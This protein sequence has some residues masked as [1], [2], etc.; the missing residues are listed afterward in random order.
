MSS[1]Q[2]AALSFL[3]ALV[4][5][6]GFVFFA[7]TGLMAQIETKFYAQTKINEKD[8]QLEKLS[9]SCNSYIS[10]IL[11]KIQTGDG[12]YLKESAV[13]TYVHQN[14]SEKEATERKNLTARLFDELED[15]GLD[16]MRLIEKNGR[17]LHYSSYESDVLKRVSLNTTYKLYSD[18]VKDSG[19]FDGELLLVD[20]DKPE[21]K[22]MLDRANNRLVISFPFYVTDNT[23][24]ATL[25]CYFELHALEQ[26]I[27][28]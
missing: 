3:S 6:A 26:Q 17:T 13:K 12:A 28:N 10:Q 18:V 9:E 5:F 1:V 11:T 25:V 27:V 22:L 20:S 8:D 16:G 7:H 19:E 24:F 2:K 23:Y 4:L 15:Y 21:T 14:P